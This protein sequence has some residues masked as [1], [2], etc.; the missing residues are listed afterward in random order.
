LEPLKRVIQRSCEIKAAVVA[1]DEKE[2]GLRAILNFG[3]TV[4]HAL[5]SATQYKCYRHGEAIAI[6]MVTACLIGEDLRITPPEVT[7]EVSACLAACGLPVE[8]PARVDPGAIQAAMTLDKKTQSGRLRFVIAEHIGKVRIVDG[9]S[10]DVVWRAIE[11]QKP[12][13]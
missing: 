3:H 6:G 2:Q 13:L 7:Q 11:R 8:F 12:P 9:V 5:E 1:E 10:P 4:G